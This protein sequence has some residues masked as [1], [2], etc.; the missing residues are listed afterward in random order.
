MFI[1]HRLKHYQDTQIGIPSALMQAA[2]LMPHALRSH[3]NETGMET[4]AV[5]AEVFLLEYT[6][7]AGFA[8]TPCALGLA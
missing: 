8:P 4:F 1:F 5:S 2:R 6:T 3:M 7:K